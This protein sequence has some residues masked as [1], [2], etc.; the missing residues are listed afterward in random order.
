MAPVSTRQRAVLI[1]LSLVVVAAFVAVG[2]GISSNGGDR[3]ATSDTSQ[4]AADSEP[5]STLPTLAPVPGSS[6]ST[7]APAP[8]VAGA[9][10]TSRP[11]VLV[12]GQPAKPTPAT[13]L[14]TVPPT[15]PSTTT[16]TT[17]PPAAVLSGAGAVL[18]APAKPSSRKFAAGSD[19]TVLLERS[20]KGG[21]GTVAAKGGNLYWVVEP[22][23]AGGRR[24]YVYKAASSSSITLVLQ[25]VDDKGTEFAEV[26]ALAA[27]VSGDGPADILF[28]FRRK[29]ATQVL[30]MDVVEGPGVVTLHRD[31]GRGSVKAAPGQIDGWGA[32]AAPG[33]FTHEVIRMVAGSW[34]VVATAPAKES[35]VPKSHI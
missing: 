13:A 34:R 4:A 32:S 10:V 15:Q 26:R 25:A 6:T 9:T 24:A 29:G 19:C 18:K 23:A 17:V 21:C 16:T 11:P 35:E 28:G 7:A 27:D 30:S 20:D 8:T 33:G 5:V 1:A 12:K 3:V 2:I 14:T 31:Y 22:T